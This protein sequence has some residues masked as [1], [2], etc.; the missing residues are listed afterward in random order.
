MK[1]EMNLK[2]EKEIIIKKEIYECDMKN[3]DLAFKLF[4]K[5]LYI[6]KNKSKPGQSTAVNTIESEVL[7]IK[8][9][10]EQ[11]TSQKQQLNQKLT[12]LEQERTKMLE[13]Y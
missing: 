11:Y 4:S 1:I 13:D 9:E 7:R 10:I 12:F 5:Q 8:E 2:F 6:T 3:E